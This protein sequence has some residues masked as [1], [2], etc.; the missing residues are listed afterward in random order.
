MTFA[1][2]PVLVFWEMTKACPLSCAHCRAD[3]IR[4]PLP[5]E[6]TTQE[7]KRLID[8]ITLFGKPYPVMIFTGGDPL[9]RKD[10]YDLLE[11]ARDKGVS[12]AV[13]PAV[14][15]SL[16]LE[17][18]RKLKDIGVSSISVSLDGSTGDTHDGIRQVAGTYGRTIDTI[19]KAI[20]IGLPIQVNTA[21]MRRNMRE[22]PAIFKL[23]RGLGVRTWEIFF[24]VKTGR[25]TGLEDLS[26]EESESVCNFLYDAS[27]Y[28][29]IIR[30]VEAP[31]IR[32]VV[33]QRTHNDLYWK[34]AVYYGMRLE[35]RS[36]MGEPHGPSTIRPLGTLDGDGIIFV[37]HNGT[38]CPGGFLPLELG[39]MK[40]DNIVDVYAGNG[41]LVKIRN[42]EF[43]GP[44]GE[45]EFRS[46][47][48]GSRARACAYSGNPLGSDPSCIRSASA[49]GD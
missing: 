21:V 22:M 38:I 33:R 35:L 4:N 25:G 49:M 2:K 44:C 45:C 3:A 14:S 47:C 30:T 32:R 16:T 40:A 9:A 28:G 24:L 12:F 19:R 43:E 20:E 39:N 29:M 7:G 26:A 17:V 10:L 36:A 6:L 1:N 46:E 42:R 23:I 48:G 8:Q 34:E 15:D 41:M 37:S 18:L 27:R 31:F 11:Y 13:S 5:G